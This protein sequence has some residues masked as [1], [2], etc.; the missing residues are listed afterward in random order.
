[1]L[2]RTVLKCDSFS[3]TYD[4]AARGFQPG[5][6]HGA[7]SRLFERY[8]HRAIV[9]DKAVRLRN[10]AER[11]L[12]AASEGQPWAIQFLA[13][14]LDGPPLPKADMGEGSFSITWSYVGANDSQVL[15][16]QPSVREPAALANENHSQAV[17]AVREDDP[18][19]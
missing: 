9:Q 6:Q 10:A 13:L 5:N 11:L 12:D 14:K 18:A 17:P 3:I 2:P 19:P 15:E 16:H 1:M 7:K 4:M 8:L